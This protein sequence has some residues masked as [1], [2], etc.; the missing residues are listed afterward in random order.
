MRNIELFNIFRERFTYFSRS[1]HRPDILR[2]LQRA[3]RE[4]NKHAV[5]MTERKK[6]HT[7]THARKA[8]NEH[9]I[10]TRTNTHSPYPNS[11]GRA[12][13]NNVKR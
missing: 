4:S 5:V 1:L 7:Q 13:T 8:K 10:A 12:T 2:S 3:I 6:T 9:T 11:Q